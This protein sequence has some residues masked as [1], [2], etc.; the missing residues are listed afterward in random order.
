MPGLDTKWIAARAAVVTELLRALRAGDEAP[1]SGSADDLHALLGLKR[2]PA[3]LRVRLLGADLRAAAGGLG[4]IEAPVAELARLPVAPRAVLVVENL[5]TGLAL[6]EW[7]GVAAVMG[8]GAA[9]RLV[10]AVGWIVQAPRCIYWGDIDSHGYAILDRA[11]SVLPKVESVLMD[12]DTLLAH[13]ELCV[14]EPVQA[15]AAGLPGL[16]AAEREVFDGLR[17]NRWGAALRLEQERIAWPL[18]LR[19]LQA[20]IGGGMHC[21]A[22]AAAPP[23]RS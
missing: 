12:V 1:D 9:V 18:A 15:A 2:A 3:R 23:V 14:A 4:D 7:P 6:P 20:R 11:R 5:E 21:P 19:E 16:T 13:L 8:L 17:S 10:G 22:A